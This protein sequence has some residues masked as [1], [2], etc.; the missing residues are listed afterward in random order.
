MIVCTTKVRDEILEMGKDLK[1]K[2]S[3]SS[4]SLPTK[5]RENVFIKKLCMGA[6]NCLGKFLGGC[7]TWGLM[8]RSCKGKT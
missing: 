8:I 3:V 1:I 7:F 5:Y 6:Q 2:H 4:A